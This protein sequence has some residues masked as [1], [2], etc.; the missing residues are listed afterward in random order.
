MTGRFSP[1]R[2]KYL[3]L[4]LGELAAVAVFA[5][6]AL[7]WQD[8]L[9]TSGALAALWCALLPLLV[10]LLQAGVY[11]LLARSWI[12]SGRMPPPT[13]QIFRVL[14]VINPIILIAGLV[15]VIAT[16]PAGPFAAAIVLLVWAFGA[17]E[18]INYY[19]VRL[20]YPW[21]Q[22]ASEVGH[23]RTPKLIKDIRAVH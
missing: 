20:S 17:I 12:T 22:W 4:G 23:W 1:L 19:I 15:G 6:A 13:A 2:S 5:T 16:F 21:T 7:L 11:W 18:Y 3:S 9:A 14:R 10:V 8:K